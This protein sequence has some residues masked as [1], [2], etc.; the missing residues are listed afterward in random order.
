MMRDWVHGVDHAPVCEIL[1]QIVNRALIMASRLA[2]TS[3]A[4][5]L[6]TPAEFPF[7]SDV[8]AA[9]T[10]R[11]GCWLLEGHSVLLGLLWLCSCTARIAYF[12]LL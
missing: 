10:L 5:T 7:L 8:T 3:S 11:E 9:S 1:L 6:S 2:C 4:G 12:L